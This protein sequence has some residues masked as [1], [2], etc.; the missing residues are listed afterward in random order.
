[1]SDIE[2]MINMPQPAH[3]HTISQIEPQPCSVLTS[4]PYTASDGLSSPMGPNPI[5]ESEA[6]SLGHVGCIFTGETYVPLEYAP[7]M[8]RNEQTAEYECNDTVYERIMINL[9]RE[10]CHFYDKISPVTE[11]SMYNVY[12]HAVGFS[13]AICPLAR[14]VWGGYNRA[15]NDNQYEL[16]ETELNLNYVNTH[17]RAVIWTG[18]YDHKHT[19]QKMVGYLVSGETF[20]WKFFTHVGPC[21]FPH[22]NCI[23]SGPE[24]WLEHTAEHYFPYDFEN[25][26]SSYWIL[27]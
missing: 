23:S 21:T 18:Y 25:E 5:P 9:A 8:E 2:V 11:T 22:D 7:S 6:C 4:V 1:M 16:I 20:T 24:G 12:N 3:E 15:V 13:S 14:D 17:N 19:Y 27:A 26:D 10:H